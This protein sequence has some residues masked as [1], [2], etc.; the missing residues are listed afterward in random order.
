MEVWNSFFKISKTSLTPCSP[1][2]QDREERR[3][4]EAWRNILST[5]WVSLLSEGTS[6]VVPGRRHAV[7]AGGL[8]FILGQETTTH[9]PWVHVPP[10]K[11]P[12]VTTE[13][14]I[15]RA[16]TKTCCSKVFLSELGPAVRRM[17]AICEIWTMLGIQESKEESCGGE[18]SWK[19]T[20]CYGRSGG[21]QA[22][23]HHSSGSVA[24]PKLVKLGG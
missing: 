3:H 9:T 16:A 8:G 10:L 15:L 23:C 19:F 7:N 20:T 2:S 1:C 5:G 11:N 22:R 6:L 17:G 14:K 4:R 24:T 21:G 13:L 12:C 18:S